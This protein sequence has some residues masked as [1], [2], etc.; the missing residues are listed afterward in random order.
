MTKFSLKKK[1][2]KKWYDDNQIMEP[3]VIR[4]S[5]NDEYVEMP[6]LIGRLPTSI[7]RRCSQ[8]PGF[9]LKSL[10]FACSL[11]RSVVFFCYVY[12]RVDRLS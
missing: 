12:P 10:F 8:V 2:L 6:N 4:A 9:F 11:K 5:S 7:I 1:K 3:L